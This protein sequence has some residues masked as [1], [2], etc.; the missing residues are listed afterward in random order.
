MTTDFNKDE[1]DFAKKAETNEQSAVLAEQYK[2]T[3]TEQLL[4]LSD[5]LLKNKQDKTK[6][7]LYGFILMTCLFLVTLMAWLAY[8]K[9]RFVAMT[10]A[11]QVCE[12]TPDKNPNLNDKAIINFAQEAVLHTNSFSFADYESKIEWT[13]SHYYNEEGRRKAVAGI[14]NLGLLDTVQKNLFTVKATIDGVPSIA[15][16]DKK[17][18]SWRI[19]VPIMVEVYGATNSAKETQKIIATVDVSASNASKI[20]TTGLG[21]SNVTYERIK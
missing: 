12:V 8:P 5:M 18:A 2:K 4:E 16:I 15:N 3:Q 19:Y 17:K 20:N 14:R 10:D 6:I 9:N 7:L 11:T 13:M 21:V 1:T